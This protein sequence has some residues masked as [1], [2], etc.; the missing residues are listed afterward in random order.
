MYYTGLISDFENR[1]HQLP[2]SGADLLIFKTEA[3]R[4][5]TGLY[6]GNYSLIEK[7]DREYKKQLTILS[8]LNVT[9]T[10]YK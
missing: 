6:S 7:W 9:G 10:I 8:G 4:Y 1:L 3:L 5:Q 2:L